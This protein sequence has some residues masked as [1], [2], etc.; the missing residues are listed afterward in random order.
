LT[1]QTEKAS[2][3]SDESDSCQS[4]YGDC[5]SEGKIAGLPSFRDKKLLT[6]I[7]GVG[8]GDQKILAADLRK[9]LNMSDSWGD[10]I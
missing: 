8:Y 9:G 1:S 10:Q 4:L 5:L 6:A 3:I 7:T 2:K